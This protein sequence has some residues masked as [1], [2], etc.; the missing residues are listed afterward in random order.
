MP[1]SPA[2]F[3]HLLT[4]WC[5]RPANARQPVLWRFRLEDT[6]TRRRYGFAS[7]EALVAFLQAEMADA[8]AASHDGSS[9]H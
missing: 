5:E 6:R 2:R 3:V 9:S 1:E 4:I 7:L 8:E